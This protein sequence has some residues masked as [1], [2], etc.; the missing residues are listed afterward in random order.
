VVYLPGAH[1]EPPSTRVRPGLDDKVIA[2]WNGLTIRAFAEAG[3]ALGEDHLLDLARD[4]ARFVLDHLVVEGT[5]MRSWRD[6]QVSVPGFLDD[7]AGVAVGLFTLFA[8][9]GEERWYEGAS[10]L[11]SGLGRF[12][13]PAGGFY[14]TPDDAHDLLKRPSDVTDNPL[15]SGNGLAAEALLMAAAYTG[16]ARWR[17]QADEALAAVA[18]YAEA[19]PSMV[20]HHL[21][22]AYAGFDPRELAIVGEGWER[23]AAVY[24]SRYRSGVALAPSVSGSAAVP[25]L[26]ER[27]GGNG[28]QAFL[29]R[30]FVCDLPTSDPD[31][32][33]AQLG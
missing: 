4:A 27:H 8:A 21:A 24:W 18:A 2:S 31:V 9:T 26:A 22:V 5:L 10:W 16:E 7:H 14:S 3:A 23:L 29:C 17:E 13:R 20:G 33:A 6:G 30:G 19:Y 32:L 25:L 1:L 11:V 12:A 28:A 15:P